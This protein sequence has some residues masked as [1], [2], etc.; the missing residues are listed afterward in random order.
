[1]PNQNDG[2]LEFRKIYK[3]DLTKATNLVVLSAC[4][5]QVGKLNHGDEVVAMK[6]FYKHLKA[7]LGK[8]E[9]RSSSSN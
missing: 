8:A 5:G 9:A 7:G 1:M 3:L 6:R 2:R 4:E